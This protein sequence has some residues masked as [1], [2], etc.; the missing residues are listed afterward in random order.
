MGARVNGI[1]GPPRKQRRHSPD[2]GADEPGKVIESEDVEVERA[3]P[4]GESEPVEGR[5]DDDKPETAL[6][7]E[8]EGRDVDNGFDQ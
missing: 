4:R 2:E 8:D 6:F 1:A 3:N 7:E 5:I